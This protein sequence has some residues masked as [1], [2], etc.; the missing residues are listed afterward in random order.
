MDLLDIVAKDLREGHKAIVRAKG[1]SMFPLIR[2]EVDQILLEPYN[3][4]L[5]VGDVIF[6]TLKEGGYLLHRV[7][8]IDDK[9]LTLKGDG[10]PIGTEQVEP[11]Q[12]IGEATGV[13]KPSKRLISK[14]SRTWWCYAHLWPRGVW[15]RR[16]IL[17]LLRLC[18]LV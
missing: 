17:K 9:T 13:I 1:S 16:L 10:N 7:I 12:V 3:G 15:P 4:R 11:S 14:G 8:K 2:S 6:V 18:H 5:S